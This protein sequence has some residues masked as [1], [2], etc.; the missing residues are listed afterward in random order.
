M[1]SEIDGPLQIQREVIDWDLVT[2]TV[3]DG[4]DDSWYKGLEGDTAYDR[5]VSFR[6]RHLQVLNICGRSKR[7]WS[8]ALDTQLKK[9]R[10]ARRGGCRKVDWD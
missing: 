7:W 2:A 6:A 1:R 3:G 10:G 9:V 4:S 8:E 5:L